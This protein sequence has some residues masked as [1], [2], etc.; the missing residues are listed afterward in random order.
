MTSI[1]Y[2]IKGGELLENKKNPKKEKQKV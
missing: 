1:G 2:Y